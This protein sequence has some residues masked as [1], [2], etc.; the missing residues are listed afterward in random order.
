MK[1][2]SLVLKAP[3]LQLLPALAMFLSLFA[4][5]AA[6]AQITPLGD[7]FTNTAD[8]TT[9]YGS[10]TLIEVDGA[11]LVTYIQFPLSSIPS[12]ASVSQ[13]TLK[14]YV[15]SVTTA[16]SFNVDYVNGAWAESTIDASNAPTLG[17]AIASNVDVTAADKN[18]Y[19]LINVTS[20]VQ[21]WLSG[22]ETNNGLALVANSTFFAAFDSKENTATSH[23]PELDIAYAGG[24]GT[25]TGVTTASGSGLTGGG[26]GGTLSLSLT[27][28]CSS[29]QVLSWNGSAWA[30]ASS[31]T[32]TITGVTAGTDL[33][34]GGTSGNVTLNLNTSALNS[35]YAQ[36][37]AANTFT[38]NQTVNGNVS[39]TGT[40]TGSG[41]QIGSKLFDYGSYAYGNAF[42]GFAGNTT[43][44]GSYN[45]AVGEQA[46]F[47]NTT[48][49]G[50]AAIGPSA[51]YANTTGDANIGDGESALF[52]NTSGNYN[53]G[54][55]E[56]ALLGNTTGSANNAFGFQ[57][58]LYNSTASNNNA[59]GFAA[60]FN[61]TTGS[62]NDA[63][64]YQ[65][66]F[67]NSTGGPNDAFGYQALYSN[68]TGY[69]NDAFGYQA[70]YSNN[71]GFGNDAFGYGALYYNNAGYENTAVGDIALQSN[72]TGSDNTALGGSALSSNTTGSFNTAVGQSSCNVT[73]ASNNTCIGYGSS[74]SVDGLTNA[75]AIGAHAAVGQS[76]SLVLGGT[77]NYAVNV[78]IGTTTPSNILTIGRG[79]GHPVSD[80]WET[81]SSRRWKTNIQTLPDALAKVEQ[82]RGVS[83]D[84]KDSGK[85]EIGVIAEEVGSVLPEVVT[86][87]DNGKDARGVDYSRLTALLI[88]A[89]KQQQ[90]VIRQQQQEIT[91]LHAQMRKRA[92]KE[93]KLESRL[94]HLEQD[95]QTEL[96]A[97]GSI[98]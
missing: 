41:F 30:C 11:S 9:N 54:V 34:G 19:I 77:G 70:L 62:P 28:A 78:G 92:T 21:A 49:S 81:Y 32:G 27:T 90:S 73:T 98:R 63:F 1:Q 8:P 75:T 68:N 7:S 95:H 61:N 82:L 15:N 10:A 83:Y 85:H 65:A 52:S 84:L 5:S 58:L 67:N 6:H 4:W 79:A 43:T 12:G 3:R 72:T 69:N 14:V 16:G 66:L 57:A 87:E 17:A 86:Y 42:L 18:Q 47:S 31:G 29:G 64:G 26:T 45:V 46:L 96:A 51:L 88:E 74:P 25:I 20:A 33:T 91:A 22:S 60:L 93:A 48:G 97:V 39:A 44:T 40:V 23:P 36:L 13:A 56:D 80:S 55:G 37:A 76:N 50:N 89:V 94:A 53:T 71:A 24:D 38:T 35:S 59:F 2:A